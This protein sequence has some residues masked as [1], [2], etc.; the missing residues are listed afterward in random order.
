MY[1]LLWVLEGWR[2]ILA[3]EDGEFDENSHLSFNDVSVD[4]PRVSA[5]SY[6][7]T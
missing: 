4:C 7:G 6:K 3:P 1:L 2:S 5:G